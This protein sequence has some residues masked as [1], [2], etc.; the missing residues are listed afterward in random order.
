HG[1]KKHEFSTPM[2]ARL[3]NEISEI[4]GTLKGFDPGFT[5]QKM[6]RCFANW[7]KGIRVRNKKAAAPNL[8]TSPRGATPQRHGA[9]DSAG[10]GMR[11]PGAACTSLRPV[12]GRCS[13]NRPLRKV[14]GNVY[15]NEK[16]ADP[17]ALPGTRNGTP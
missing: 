17:A 12:G 8:E 11:K 15:G 4:T 6:L 1:R 16:P 5:M 7:K 2:L 10:A 13:I 3:A 14:L 9:S